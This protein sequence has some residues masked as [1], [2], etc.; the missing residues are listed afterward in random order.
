[1]PTNHLNT[2]IK[3]VVGSDIEIYFTYSASRPFGVTLPNGQKFGFKNQRDARNCIIQYHN[4][5]IS[6]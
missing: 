5:V 4:S 6:K 1:M 2:I 3:Q